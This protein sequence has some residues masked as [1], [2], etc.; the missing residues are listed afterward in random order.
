VA[1][2]QAPELTDGVIRLR[3]LR[4]EDADAMVA[5]LQDPEIPRWTRVPSP[6]THV[7]FEQWLASQ[8]ESRSAGEG[9][10]LVV[11]DL[12]GRLL[13]AVGV[14]DLA[15]DSGGDIGYWVAREARGR[16]VATRAVRLLRDWLAAELGRPCLEI[17]VHPENVVSQRVAEAAGFAATG[18][19]RRDPRPDLPGDY[20]VFAWPD[21]AA[22]GA[23]GG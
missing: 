10:H 3:P 5:A 2:L 7:E 4:A 20:M 16:G 18:E 9:V 22:A 19:Y 6:Y 11:T 8:A 21:D 15:T 12:D 23:G 17:L 13:G 1:A 14:Q